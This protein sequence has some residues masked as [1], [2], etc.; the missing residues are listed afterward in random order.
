[1]KWTLRI[2]MILHIGFIL[3]GIYCVFFNDE[4]ISSSKF[5][6]VGIT[7]LFLFLNAFLL[8]PMNTIWKKILMVLS[9]S[10]YGIIALGFWRPNV[11][12]NYWEILF[13]IVIFILINSLFERIVKSKRNWEKWSFPFVSVGVILPFLL[14]FSSTQAMLVSTLLLFVLT[15]YLLFKAVRSI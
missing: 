13:A 6:F 8:L 12:K 2:L 14:F 9:I 7:G 1:M 4:Y 5:I 3:Y 15:I 11:F 10:M